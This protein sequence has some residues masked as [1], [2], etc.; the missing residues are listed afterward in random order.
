MEENY[1]VK[2]WNRSWRTTAASN[3]SDRRSRDAGRQIDNLAEPATPMKP[4]SPWFSIFLMDQGCQATTALGT[5]T[6]GTYD[7]WLV[8]FKTPYLLWLIVGDF[9][10]HATA[11]PGFRSGWGSAA[12]DG[13]PRSHGRS[14]WP[15][16]PRVPAPSIGGEFFD[17]PVASHPLPLACCLSPCATQRL[18]LTPPQICSVNTRTVTL[19]TLQHQTTLHII[20]VPAPTYT[21][22]LT[23][24]PTHPSTFLPVYLNE[25]TSTA[26][27][28][29]VESLD[30]ASTLRS[31][32]RKGK[33]VLSINALR[34]SCNL[35][36][37]WV[38]RVK[39][40]CSPVHRD[41]PSLDPSNS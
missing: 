7:S 38:M 5:A 41:S 37:T 20:P 30:Q 16:P 21:Y 26:V 34:G 19:A 40:Q 18:F 13:T 3:V 12:I 9:S 22:L 36:E 2:G 28:L 29:R 27:S 24:L 32:N 11:A 4:V 1:S 23:Y 17:S 35:R 8:G 14:S 25:V 10:C 33:L 39:R 31:K 6:T 15:T